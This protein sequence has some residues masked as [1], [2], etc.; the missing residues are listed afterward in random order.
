[1][2]LGNVS[3]LS[4]GAPYALPAPPTPRQSVLDL[5]PSVQQRTV[6]Q[7]APG[8]MRCWAVAAKNEEQSAGCYKTGEK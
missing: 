8:M 1:M 7:L 5:H 6:G 4:L 2:N 3:A